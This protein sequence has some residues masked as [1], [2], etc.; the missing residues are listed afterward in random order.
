[1]NIEKKHIIV[2]GVPR[3][4]KTLSICRRLAE[5]NHYQLVMMD[6]IT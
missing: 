2:T 6:S 1:M 5:T 3:T 4:G